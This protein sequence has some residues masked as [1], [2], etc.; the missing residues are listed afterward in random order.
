MGKNQITENAA[1]NKNMKKNTVSFRKNII[2]A[3][4]CSAGSGRNI[5]SN[6][7]IGQLKNTDHCDHRCSRCHY[8]CKKRDGICTGIPAAGFLNDELGIKRNCGRNHDGG[9][10]HGS[11]CP[12]ILENSRKKKKA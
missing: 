2:P 4:L 6:T 8:P 11:F 9:H 5:S 7:A 3:V 10:F 1:A 12:W